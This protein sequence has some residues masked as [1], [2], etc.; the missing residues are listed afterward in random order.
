MNSREIGINRTLFLMTTIIVAALLLLTATYWVIERRR[1]RENAIRSVPAF[2]FK[3]LDGK[4]FSRDSVD[5]NV[6]RLVLNYYN[7]DCDHC[8]YVA[9][10]I[11]KNAVKFERIQLLMI[12][13]ADKEKVADFCRRYQL[14]SVP[15][16][17]LLLDTHHEFETVFGTSV[18]PSFF[19]YNYDGKLVEKIIGE[20]K[21]EN[22]FASKN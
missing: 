3:Q 11:V 15:N 17:K 12:T 16:L 18:T 1:L 13:P 5:F 6:D 8:Q 9:D 20:T 22:L 4:S 21:V 14:E 7:P 2:D 10:Q 19:I